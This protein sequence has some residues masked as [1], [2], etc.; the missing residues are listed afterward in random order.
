M[1]YFRKNFCKV[2]FSDVISKQNNESLDFD[3]EGEEKVWSK[4]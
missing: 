1:I 3:P 4:D 2:L